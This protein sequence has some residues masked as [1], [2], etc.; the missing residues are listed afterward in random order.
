MA[1]TK[2]LDVG[3][4]ASATSVSI[5]QKNQQNAA[6]YRPEILVCIGQAQ[7]GKDVATN[8]LVLASGNADD[9]GV[10]YG[11]GSPLHRMARKL[12]PKSG[13]GSKV[14]T[15][16]MAVDAPSTG[17]AEV[18]TLTIKADEKIKKSLNA[19]FVLN[20]LVFEAAADVAGKVATNAHNNPA[21]APRG[22]NLNSFEKTAYPFTLTKGMT[23][24]DAA[25][26]IKEALEENLELPFAVALG[27]TE[28]TL[29]LTGKWVGSDS[30]FEFEIL[31][32]KYEKIDSSVYG[33]TFSTART[34]E[35]AGVGV[36]PDEALEQMDEEF[37]VT[38][39]V[40]QYASSTVLD[41]MQEYFEAFHDGL[42]AQ[43][44][45]CYSAIEAPESTLVPGTWDVQ[46]LMDAGN[47]RR[48]DSIN[49]QIV[50][51]FGKLRKLKYTERNRLAKAGFSNLVKKQDGSYK[52]MD[53]ITFYHPI[54]KTNPIFRFDRDITVI[55]N[56]AYSFMKRFRDSDEW[57]SVIFVGTQDITTNPDA[58]NLDDVKAAVNNEI[59]LQGQAAWI[60][61]YADAQKETQVEID[62]SNPNR[63]NIN[64]KFD[65]SGV[66]RIFDFTN[67]VGFN[68]KG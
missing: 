37:G 44:V 27:E 4:I 58:R 19:Y 66:G 57:K 43:Y 42:I 8:E 36:I 64:P 50:G 15:Y 61:N 31:N 54:G 29:T 10:V 47:D 62:S 65:L 51:D 5:Q 23:V 2:S 11:F 13:N 68:F 22:T 6:S 17:D 20:D 45:I 55:G 3:A 63:V 52:L 7:T 40:S 24:A 12:F 53:L 28:G 48:E 41:A 67:F 14:D 32:D 46:S 18:Q 49:V 39:V 9:V 25:K 38:R 34:T 1:I 35:A 56:S 33:V 30:Y 16:F 59:S 21:K 26:A 60:A